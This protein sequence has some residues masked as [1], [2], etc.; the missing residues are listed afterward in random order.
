[1]VGR[2][3]EP[4]MYGSRYIRSVELPA[5]SIPDRRYPFNI[6]AIRNLGRLPLHPLVTFLVGENGTGKSTLTEAIAA[7]TDLNPEGGSKHHRFETRATESRLRDHLR[8]QRGIMRETDGFFL[9][10]EGMYNV[11]TSLEELGISPSYYGGVSLHSRS[12]G[13]AF[14][15]VAMHR[16]RGKGL[17]VMDEPESALSPRRQIEMLKRIHILAA[18]KSSQF[19]IATHSP[20]LLSYPESVIYQCDDDGIAEV[21]YEDTDIFRTM[22]DFTASPDVFL[23]HLL[24]DLMAEG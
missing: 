18:K 17:Y 8:V 13:E 15:A 1:M 22:R 24:G 11:A 23:H 10:A 12:H 5:A 7:L 14:L 2:F 3:I 21:A 9:R 4:D 16:F 6:P 20:I 19:V